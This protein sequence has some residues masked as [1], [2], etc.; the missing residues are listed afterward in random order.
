MTEKS[1]K[2]FIVTGGDVSFSRGMVQSQATELWRGVDRVEL[3]FRGSKGYQ[4]RYGERRSKKCGF[5]QENS[6]GG[7][8]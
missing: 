7:C 6:S 4:K 8:E 2:Y 3:L 5:T 1:T